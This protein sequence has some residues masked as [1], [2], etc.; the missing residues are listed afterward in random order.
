MYLCISKALDYM[1]ARCTFEFD[2]KNTRPNSE[3]AR[4]LVLRMD[5]IDGVYCWRHPVAIYY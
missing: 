3:F 1:H 4:K 5:N 2:K